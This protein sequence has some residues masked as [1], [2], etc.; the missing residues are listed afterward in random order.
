VATRELVK[1]AREWLRRGGSRRAGRL[2]YQ[3]LAAAWRTSPGPVSRNGPLALHRV[4]LSR[5]IG[6]AG[7]SVVDLL[8]WEISP[9]R[10]RLVAFYPVRPGSGYGPAAAGAYPLD[11]VVMI[12]NSTGEVGSGVVVR[13]ARDDRPALVLTALHVV[14]NGVA[15]TAGGRPVTAWVSIPVDS[16]GTRGR[17]GEAATAAFDAV[18]KV[19]RVQSVDLAL[20]EVDGLDAPAVP[21]GHVE[22]GELVA[23]DG[24]P[25]HVRTPMQG[26]VTGIANGYLTVPVLQREGVSGGPAINTAGEVVGIASYGRADLLSLV[27]PILIREFL[28]IAIP[29]LDSGQH[30]PA[31]GRPGPWH[32]FGQDRAPRQQGPSTGTPDHGNNNGGNGS[33]AAPNSSAGG[34]NTPNS[35]G[36]GGQAASG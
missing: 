25:H 35:G 31:P 18:N 26:P 1:V 9:G 12:L 14:E 36:S 32:W 29:I 17:L 22:A 4:D 10:H 16:Y 3:L 13:A 28:R 20:L 21:I 27:A 5:P 30:I 33:P 23:V 11:S 2:Y 34:A 15:I 19:G 7:T 6:T 24:F 8:T